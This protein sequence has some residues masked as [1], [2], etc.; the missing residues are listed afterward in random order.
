MH[1]QLQNEITKL[2][3]KDMDRRDFLK[4][5]GIGFAGI[6]G[7]TSILKTIGTLNG[8]QKKSANSGYGSNPYGG[9]KT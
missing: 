4:H 6:M 5:V 9:N 8:S 2:M 7:V 1:E 3:Q